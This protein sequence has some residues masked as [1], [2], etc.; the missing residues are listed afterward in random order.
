MPSDQDVL[1]E[2]SAYFNNTDDILG[3]LNFDLGIVHMNPAWN[4]HTG[5]MTADIVDQNIINFVA[6]E[7]RS[8]AQLVLSQCLA[9]L[10]PRR[11]RCFLEYK[12]GTFHP[13]NWHLTPHAET[14]RIY[15]SLHKLSDTDDQDT[16]YARQ[17]RDVLT[18]R[19]RELH[20]LNLISSKISSSLQLDK[21]LGEIAE[22]TCVALNATSAYVCEVNFEAN[23]TTVL[24]E[25]V[26]PEATPEEQQSDTGTTY[27]LDEDF[28]GFREWLENPDDALIHMIEDQDLPKHDYDYMSAF[29]AKAL[30][31]VPLLVDGQT[32]GY[33]EIWES[34]HMRHFSTQDIQVLQTIASRVAAAVANAKLY[35]IMQD[36]EQRYRQIVDNASDFIFQTDENGK[37]IF[38]NP[39]TLQA[40]G[41]EPHEFIGVSYTKLIPEPFVD[42]ITQF[43]HHQFNER[44]PETYKEFPFKTKNGDWIWLGNIVQIVTEGKYVRGFYTIA[45]D[46][47]QRKQFEQE[48]E[49]LIEDL[50]AFAHTV[51]HDLKSPLNTIIGYS[52]LLG[53]TDYLESAEVELT[54]SIV[55]ISYR[56]SHIT[57][58]LLRLA[59]VRNL[60]EIYLEELN[61]L[62]ILANVTERLGYM[63]KESNAQLIVADS[64]EPA[65]GYASWI[66]EIFANYIS[67]AIKYGGEPPIIEVGSTRLD[68]K[69][70]KYWVRDN[71]QGLTEEAKAN[72]FAK[73]TR[74][75]KIRATGHGL[76]L[77]I[78]KRIIDKLGGEL[79]VQTKLGEGSTFSFILPAPE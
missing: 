18:Q 37:F 35:T 57:D 25:Y 27:N 52:S 55:R 74:L 66:E 30:V 22:L 12:D 78:V 43:Y 20:I 24:S 26:S 1:N 62:E 6:T 28:P 68:D 10:T 76:G 9:E 50:E 56:M 58:E 69:R 42:D 48:R 29:G 8:M 46:I 40:M 3:S 23:T 44:I 79:D 53:M 41:Y 77:S 47:T 63:I 70:V 11:L 64:F 75:E 38:A 4:R 5:F 33:L 59:E 17:L 31:I 72:L 60:E 51:A 34:R 67:N 21:I 7:D 15:L 2:Q 16:E 45:R 14:E 19:Y 36:S 73:Y 49:T 61:I 65:M 71:G 32:W 13:Y 54:E 39:A